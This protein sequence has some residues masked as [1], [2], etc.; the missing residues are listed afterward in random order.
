MD[1]SFHPLYK[2]EAKDLKNY[3]KKEKLDDD[4]NYV[5]GG[6]GTLLIYY[7]SDKPNFL[8]SPKA[9]KGYYCSARL[10]NYEESLLKYYLSPKS[11][12]KE[13]LTIDAFINGKKIKDSALNEVLITEGLNYASKYFVKSQ[14]FE[15]LEINSGLIVYTSQG[16]SG[17]AKNLGANQV[18]EEEIG[19]CSVAKIKGLITNEG[20]ILNDE[21][22]VK[23]LPRNRETK[24]FLYIDC[25]NIKPFNPF[26]S[27][28]TVRTKPYKLS[29]NDELLL[30]KGNLVTIVSKIIK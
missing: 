12:H 21:L 2:K 30:K 18:K 24:F 8:I 19:L 26:C 11:F 13:Y 4:V 3:L 22:L 9:S 23:I 6:D 20:V 16:W 28:K 17:F 14:N 1:I 27:T 7:S 15:G 25:K 29:L 5:I 10:E